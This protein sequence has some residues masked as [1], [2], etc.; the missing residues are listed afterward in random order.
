LWKALTNKRRRNDET[1]PIINKPKHQKM[2]EYKEQNGRT[3]VQ[4]DKRTTQEGEP[5]R[6]HEVLEPPLVMRSISNRERGGPPER[7]PSLENA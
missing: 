4:E 3:H 6:E 5:Q 2:G 7:T 1:L